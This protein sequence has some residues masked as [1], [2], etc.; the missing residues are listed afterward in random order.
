MSRRTLY[1]QVL[2]DGQL[3]EGIR[4]SLKA[5]A[6]PMAGKRMTISIEESRDKRNLDQ[7]GL[8]WSCIIPHIRKVRFESGDPVTI[9]QCHED[10]LQEFAPT[11]VQRKLDNSTY[12]RP[13]RSK[14]MSVA[15][16]AAFITAITQ[17]M[18]SF[19]H[20]VPTIDY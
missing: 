5:I 16:F 14:E 18:A 13:M 7:N 9:E 4:N 15:E 2:E 8:Y 17:T 6:K 1:F 12:T 3:P 11:V 19:G 20:P 10:L